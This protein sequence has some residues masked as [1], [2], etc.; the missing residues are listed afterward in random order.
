M[1]EKSWIVSPSPHIK[2]KITTK[3]IMF[4][5]VMALLPPTAAGVYFF[6]FRA[7]TVIASSTTAAVLTE[8]I[9]SNLMDKEFDMDGSAVVTGL[10]LALVLPPT[11]PMW[12]A[13]AG[14]F[15]A[16][17]L[18]KFA[19]GGLG[20]NI[21]NPALV[22][23]IFVALSWPG[24]ISEWVSPFDAVS[25]ATPLA[26][27][28]SGVGYANISELFFGNVGGCIGETSALAILVGGAFL[29]LMGYIDWR[30]P[31]FYVGSVG[32]MMWILGENPLF[33]MLAG[34]LM[35]GAFFMA[36]D[37][38]TTPMTAEGKA[39]FS[40]GAAIIVVAIRMIG[41]YPEGVA[42]SILIMNGFT[43]LIDRITKNRVYGTESKLRRLLEW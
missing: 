36:T 12:T 30:T 24:L 14:A 26:R 15:V 21:F 10:L 11:T 3:K 25:T 9:S 8:Y 16:I 5:M 20:D 41:G 39:I 33:H 7:L 31:V 13:A 29:I 35:F 17:A 19:F 18:G 22:G 38:V 32:A 43:P 27:W 23:R 6:G 40:M 34:G 42:F 4:G 37:Y 2:D 28:G 1:S